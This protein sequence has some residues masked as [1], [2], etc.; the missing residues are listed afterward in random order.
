[1]TS[2]KKT[3]ASDWV[4]LLW[5]TIPFLLIAFFWNQ[6]PDQIAMRWNARGEVTSWGTKGIE[7]FILPLLGVGIYL[8]LLAVPYIDPKR[9][10]ASEQKAIRAIRLIFPLF[11]SGVFTAMLMQWIGVDVPMMKAMILV[12]AV[13]FIVL[14]NYLPSLRPNYFIGI[15]TPWTLENEVIWR[16]THRFGSKV[17][18]TT[19]TVMLIL[20][21]VV[22][23]STFM[24]VFIIG[25]LA[26]TLTPTIYS[27][28]LFLQQKRTSNEEVV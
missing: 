1:M 20:G 12:M 4:A 18:I 23:D 24:V 22:P 17:W 19:S 11:L 8:L 13:L 27:L 5:L 25:I 15:R 16:K 26:M 3:L 9:K 10:A 6:I 21:I 28:V 2:I 14:G 7:V